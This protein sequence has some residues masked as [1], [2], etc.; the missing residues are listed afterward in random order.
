LEEPSKPLKLSVGRGRPQLNGKAFGGRTMDYLGRI[1]TQSE[2]PS[3][4]LQRWIALIARHPMLAPVKPVTGINPFTRKP[5]EYRPHPGA[6]R[7]ILDGTEIGSMTWAED[8]SSQI[9]VWA[10][11]SAVDKIAIEV[12][13]ELG[14]VFERG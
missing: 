13:A 14:C 8:G 3:V 6:A 10:A 11:S 9:D 2:P 12:A 5:Q 4:D 7:V 1:T